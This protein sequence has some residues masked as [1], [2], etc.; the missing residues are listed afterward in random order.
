[1]RRLRFIALLLLACL[2]GVVQA[3]PHRATRLGNPATR[4]AEPLSTP[5]DLRRTLAREDLRADVAAILRMSGYLGSLQDFQAALARAEI[6]EVSY[7]VGARLPAMST[8]IQGKAALLHEVLWAGE[9]PLP[10]YEFLVESGDRVY[11]VVTPKACSNFWVEEQQRPRL[12]LSCD[13]PE[14]GLVARPVTLCHRIANTGNAPAAG[15]ALTTLVPAGMELVD[16][17]TPAPTDRVTWTLPPVAPGAEQSACATFRPIRA[18]LASFTTQTS[19]GLPAATPCTTRI[20]GIPAVLLEVIDLRDPVPVGQ[21]VVYEIRVL[22]QG[23]ETLRTLRVHATLE[24]GQTFLAATGPTPM[25]RNGAV[26]AS[27]PLASLEPK[28]EAVWRITVRADKAADVRFKVDLLA[29]PFKRP[30]SETEATLQ[31]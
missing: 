16:P 4:F 27:K 23:S 21:D 11:R 10:A 7:P 6:R 14:E 20:R 13:A 29:E 5:D 9:A 3:E 17:A 8:R 18:G 24:D 22:N 30:V 26:L 25:Q 28:Q 19:G 2:C 12:S 31:Y 1:M 15:A